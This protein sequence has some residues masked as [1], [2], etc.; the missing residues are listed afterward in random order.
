MRYELISCGLLGH[1]LVGTDA[2]DLREQ[3]SIF[4]RPDLATGLRWHRCLR[5][6]S[7]V[8]LPVPDNPARAHPPERDQITLPL[9]GRPL[10]DK[11]VLRA[12]AV[13]RA[14]HFL[15]LGILAVAI[16]VFLSHRSE[17]R[18]LFYRVI[19]AV[20]GGLGGPTSSSHS[21]ILG[22]VRKL[23]AL[24][25]STLFTLGLVVAAYAILEGVESVG[26]WLRKRWAEYLT[27]V[28]TTVL[29]VPEIYEL[30]GRISVFKILALIVNLLV[31]TYLLVAKRLFGLRGGGRAER[32]EIERDSG[33]K[34]LERTLPPHRLQSG[35]PTGAERP[36]TSA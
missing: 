13:E 21:T 32:A 25:N 6:D 34:A 22:D 26:L 14:F 17:L 10:R 1:E 23:F 12:I 30:T 5:C 16:F 33:W 4:A 18:G 35:V 36:G 15:V 20:Q 24:S 29:L 27:F 28:A 11:F 31:V 3:D 7:W 19:I 9:R 2:A 8:P